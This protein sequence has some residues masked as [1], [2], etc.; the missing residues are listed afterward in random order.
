[1]MSKQVMRI[2]KYESGRSLVEIVG[3]LALMG[4]LTAASFVLVQSG[5]TA[6]KISKAAD[7]IST[8]IA[9]VRTISAERGDFC[10]IPNCTEYSTSGANLAGAILD[11]ETKVDTPV[12]G[13]Y[14]VCYSNC[15]TAWVYIYG[16]GVDDCEMMASRAYSGG[17]AECVKDNKT[18][19]LKVKYLF[20]M[21]E[22]NED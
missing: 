10:G 3:V 5:M 12:G 6:Q 13:K 7:H 1:M 22:S 4:L 2:Q 19:V 21:S 9:N 18:Y 17:I 8:L 15:N 16:L 11:S 14:S 20:N